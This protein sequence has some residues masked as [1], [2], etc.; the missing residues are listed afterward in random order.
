M[1][2]LLAE[3]IVCF[4]AVLGIYF[5]AVRMF[6]CYTAKRS[7]I[8]A[9]ITV[10]GINNSKN[11]E[12]AIRI[13]ACQIAHSPLCDIIQSIEITS[14]ATDNGELVDRLACEF[15]NIKKEE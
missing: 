8:K 11:A 9:K 10:H 1:L 6:D 12:Y 3:I 4:F 7:G 5:S 14:S 15:E 13:L 2:Y